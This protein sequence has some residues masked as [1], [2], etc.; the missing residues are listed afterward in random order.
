MRMRKLLVFGAVIAAAVTAASLTARQ[1]FRTWGIVPDE[2]SRPLPGDDLIP[3]AQA[4]DT[5]GITIE[6]APDRVWPWLVQMGFGRGG[7]YSIDQL[8]MRAKSAD[9]IVEEWQ[10]L[11]VG[12]VLPTYP[13]GGFQVKALDRNRSLVLF[14]DPSTM[15]PPSE[16]ELEEMPAGLEA[17][18]TFLAQTPTDFK[19][20]WAFVLEPAGPNRTRLIERMRYW[21]G[22]GTP[23]SSAALSMLGFGAF[24]MMQRQ[25]VGIRS[26]A[27]Q[28]VVEESLPP[29][30]AA[31]PAGNGHDGEVPETILASA[32]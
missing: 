4:S 30:L 10:D 24:V 8:D 18:S 21:G 7:W 23:A 31:K 32:E 14:G 2:A 17:S 11:A 29:I 3:D 20:S 15:Q 12:D 22:E 13:G 16:A 9:R 1:W 5:R 25:M 27:E 19:A 28:L 6:A 26:R